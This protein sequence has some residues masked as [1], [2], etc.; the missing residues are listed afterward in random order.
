MR[1]RMKGL[2]AMRCYGAI[3]IHYTVI[4]SN[5]MKD[6]RFTKRSQHDTRFQEV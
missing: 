6:Y 3:L 2:D 4:N 5:S 1:Q